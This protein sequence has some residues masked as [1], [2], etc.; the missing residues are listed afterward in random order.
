VSEFQDS[1]VADANLEPSF[2]DTRSKKAPVGCSNKYT[3]F[4]ASL[5]N[6]KKDDCYEKCVISINSVAELKDKAANLP[7]I[8]SKLKPN[9]QFFRALA[10]AD[11]LL[12]KRKGGY[13]A[14]TE[15]K[16]RKRDQ[17]AGKFE[18][19][20]GHG[21]DMSNERKQNLKQAGKY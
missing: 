21:E 4:I 9:E 8:K 11:M 7:M 3:H 18:G 12:V 13:T 20:V 6:L 14:D 16:G 10:R 2:W 15:H 17:D 1:D 5:M 19:G